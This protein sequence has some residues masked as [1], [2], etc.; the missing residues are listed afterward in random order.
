[1]DGPDK[2]FRSIVGAY[3]CGRPRWFNLT[4][5]G[6]TLAVALPRPPLRRSL[7]IIHYPSTPKNLLS[8]THIWY[9]SYKQ[10]HP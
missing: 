5:I 4:P 7:T 2:P 8:L 9:I 3:P 10:Y 1:M 6:R